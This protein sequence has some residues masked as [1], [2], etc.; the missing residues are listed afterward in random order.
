MRL[1]QETA[2]HISSDNLSERIP[3]SPVEDEISNLARLLNRMFDRL[4]SSFNQVRL[5][6]YAFSS[7][8]ES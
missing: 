8:S 6:G 5:T 1:I 4:E 7:H 3:V 2:N